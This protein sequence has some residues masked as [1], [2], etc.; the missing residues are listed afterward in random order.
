MA[1]LAANSSR[2]EGGV[3]APGEEVLEV[4]EGAAGL[5]GA[6]EENGSGVDMGEWLMVLRG[7]STYVLPCVDSL[8]RSTSLLNPAQLVHGL[9]ALAL[10]VESQNRTRRLVLVQRVLELE[11]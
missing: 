3:E 1:A 5:A 10:V 6:E 7:G 8:L 9:G 2:T 11:A 4:L